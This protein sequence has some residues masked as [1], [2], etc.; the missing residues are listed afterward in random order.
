MV[1]ARGWGRGNWELVMRGDRVSVL[2]D[3]RVL[4]VHGWWGR[5][6]DNVNGLNVTEP[7]LVKMVMM[8]KEIH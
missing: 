6:P 8:Q 4:G 7:P 3:E 1:L 2:Q 5:M